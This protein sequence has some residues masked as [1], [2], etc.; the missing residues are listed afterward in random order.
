MKPL[1]IDF[2][3]SQKTTEK[4]GVKYKY[5]PL[6]GIW[7]NVHRKRGALYGFQGER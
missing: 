6:Y 5:K 1:I 4:Y 2:Y 7:F 3:Y